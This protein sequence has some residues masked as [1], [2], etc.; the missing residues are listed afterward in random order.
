MKS[1]HQLKIDEYGAKYE[2]IE[3]LSNESTTETPTASVTKKVDTVLK[4]SDQDQRDALPTHK[5]P[6]RRK[7]S[8]ISS[9]IASMTPLSRKLKWHTGIVYS[10]NYCD[11]EF[12]TTT[13]G[14]RHLKKV[15][16]LTITRREEYTAHISFQEKKYSCK[17]CYTDVIHAHAEITVHLKKHDLK[18]D[19]YERKYE[20]ESLEISQNK[21]IQFEEVD[22][23]DKLLKESTTS[24]KLE[25][26]DELDRSNLVEQISEPKK[27]KRNGEDGNKPISKKESDFSDELQLFIE[28]I[29]SKSEKISKAQVEAGTSL[30]ESNTERSKRITQIKNEMMIDEND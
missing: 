11:K 9:K 6:E 24:S 30:D 14:P 22:V 8:K 27:R 2:A 26:L 3:P 28:K 17:I 29:Q 10:C 12:F 15:H 13:S 1:Q 4:S 21:S 7:S 23:H 18:I 5:S 16:D 20:S 19:Q 25:T